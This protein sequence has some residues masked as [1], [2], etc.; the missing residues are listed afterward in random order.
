MN[1]CL[2]KTRTEG[3]Q[4]RGKPVP[5]KFL[6]GFRG[7]LERNIRTVWVEWVPKGEIFCNALDELRKKF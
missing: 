5:P 2:R 1:S 3:M 4:F 6:R 7:I